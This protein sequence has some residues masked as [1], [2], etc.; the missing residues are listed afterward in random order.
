MV[1][2]RDLEEECGAVLEYKCI[3]FDGPLSAR[4]CVA[5]SSI[6]PAPKRMLRQGVN[7]SLTFLSVSTKAISAVKLPR[8]V[9]AEPKQWLLMQQHLALDQVSSRNHTQAFAWAEVDHRE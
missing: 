7:N 1:E 9:S 6:K 2:A 4:H 5:A 8:T 3:C